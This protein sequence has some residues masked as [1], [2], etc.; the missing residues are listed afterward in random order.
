MTSILQKIQ[1]I[2][3]IFV[4]IFADLNRIQYTEPLPHYSNA[5]LF[6]L[7]ISHS[8]GF[9]AVW[10]LFPLLVSPL[11]PDLQIVDCLKGSIMILLFWPYSSLHW[12]HHGLHMVTCVWPLNSYSTL[13]FT[14]IIHNWLFDITTY[15]LNMLF[16]VNI[17]KNIPSFP[18][19]PKP[20]LP[21]ISMSKNIYI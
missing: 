5:L 16:K 14:L 8:L 19:L 1:K 21:I 4:S 17:S 18:S 11:L 2:H 7:L 9:S 12:F 3:N 13:G 15:M 10:L 20:L 6:K